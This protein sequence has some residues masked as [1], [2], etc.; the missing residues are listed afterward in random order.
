M[1]LTLLV[2]GSVKETDLPSGRIMEDTVPYLCSLEQ[3]TGH[4]IYLS[5]EELDLVLH[6]RSLSRENR[7]IVA[8]FIK[9]AA[10]SAD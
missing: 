5:E 1:D 4:T 6:F 10:D 3:K 2:L 7:Q 9:S 8:G